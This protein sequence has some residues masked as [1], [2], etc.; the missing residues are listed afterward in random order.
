MISMKLPAIAVFALLLV[1]GSVYAAELPS[2]TD[3]HVND[4]AGI[5]SA[6][7][8]SGLRY[9]LAGLEQNTTA[10]VVV[11][12]MENLSGMASSDYATQLFNAW[13]VGKSSGDNGLLILYA[14]QE[15]KIWVTT[16]YGMEGIL[17]DSKI[18]RLLDDYYVP[19]RDSGNAAQGIVDFTQAAADVISSGGGSE[20][21][22]AGSQSDGVSPYVIMVFVLMVLV[23]LAIAALS[24]RAMSVKCDKCGAKM[25]LIRT[26]PPAW[27]SS[28][29][30]YVYRCP[31]GHEKRIKRSYAAAGIAGGYVGG[32]F[33]GGFGGGGGGFGGG[34]SGGGGAGR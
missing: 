7:Q 32:G 14:K 26:E 19:Q 9:M 22:S 2:Y 29:Y 33:G 15:N 25:K 3:K 31:K 6:E 17:P 13:R 30:I 11:V 21:G 28:G 24:I 16:G 4:F 1:A 8:I 10:E 18:G 12:T 5:F 27:G 34:G 20:W 23:F